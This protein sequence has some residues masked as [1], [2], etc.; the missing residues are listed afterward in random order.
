MTVTDP[1]RQR[2]TKKPG[3]TPGFFF[4]FH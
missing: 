4:D 3:T 2:K 1:H